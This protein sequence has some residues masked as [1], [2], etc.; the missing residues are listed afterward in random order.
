MEFLNENTC[1]ELVEALQAAGYEWHTMF[2]W[3]PQNDAITF[4]EHCEIYASDETP[5]HLTRWKSLTPAFTMC[6]LWPMVSGQMILGNNPAP[7][8]EI[9]AR[10]L[11]LLRNGYPVNLPKKR[12]KSNKL[13]N[14]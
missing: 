2:K 8:A 11:W 14:Q 5:D 4:D 13:N 12:T 1:R 7:T 9:A 6:E 3:C 10:A